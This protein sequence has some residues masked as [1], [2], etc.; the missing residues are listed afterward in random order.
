MFDTGVGF[1]SDGVDGSW[2]PAVGRSVLVVEDEPLLRELVASALRARGFDV[3]QAGTPSQARQ[4]FLESDPDAVVM[5]VDLGP[6]PDGFELAEALLEHGTGAAVVFLT[7]LPD[8]RFAG[9]PADRLPPGVAYLNKRAII[10]IEVLVRTLDA[11]LRGQ[12]EK[13]MRH[14]QDAGRPFA[15]LTAHQVEILRLV[16]LGATNARI[17]ELT[18]TRERAVAA[19]ISRVFEALGLDSGT[20]VN[21]R[22]SAARRF[23]RWVGSPVPLTQPE[24]SEP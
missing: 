4:A 1:V 2:A 23:F 14:D 13:S 21:L 3:V 5:D 15:G 19:T 7:N 22:V 12:V 10:D 18:G 16:A 17:A 11:A 20:D 6:G 8:P 24:A 9:R